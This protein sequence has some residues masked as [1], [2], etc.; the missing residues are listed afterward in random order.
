MFG[1]KHLFYRSFAAVLCIWLLALVSPAEARRLALVVGN[2]EYQNVPALK[3]ATNDARAM[4]DSLKRLGFEVTLLTD[5]GSDE[6]WLKLDAFSKEAETAESTMLFYSGHAFQLSGV[7]YLVPVGAKLTNRES[8]KTETW[9][10]DGIIARLQN[11]KR[12]T[13][14]FLDACR[15]DPL[16]AGVRGSGATADGLARLQTGV[17]T[18]VAFATEPGAVTFDGAGEAEHSPFTTAL[19]DNIEK[20]GLSVS[21]MMIKVRNQVEENT[22]RRQTPWDQS[23]LR[24][25]FYF[26]P[27]EETKQELSAADFE[28]LA[29]LAP[30]DRRKFLDLLRASGFNERSLKEAEAAI[31]V[32]SLDLEMAAE[33]E[34][35]LGD[36]GAD[37]AGAP[38]AADPGAAD[39]V[40]P[41]AFLDDL[42]VVDGGVTI[43]D[44]PATPD[45]TAGAGPTE[46]AAIDPGPAP[47]PPVNQPAQDGDRVAGLPVDPAAADTPAGGEAPPVRL[48]ALSWETRGIL[49]INALTVDRLRVA[50]K[51]VT[52]DNEENRKLL[53]SIDPSLVEEEKPE[54]LPADLAMA[55]QTE[56]KR[57]GCYQMRVD[58]DWGRGSRTALTSYFL[59]K[60]AVPDSL[61]PTAAL[62]EQLMREDKVVCT[63]RVATAK[64]RAGTK[65]E[66]TVAVKEKKKQAKAVETKKKITKSLIGVGSF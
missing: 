31:E 7:N 19:L 39:P 3:N 26:V 66:E 28:L 2:A 22:F 5:V 51:R 21:D 27:E 25:Q 1:R 8:I 65:P 11:R 15:N 32:A 58:G 48:A 37:Q 35:T 12:Q 45:T 40:D 36:S 18:F 64:P 62:V 43:G 52:P 17:G 4:A 29:Q 53:A 30:D 59:A 41:N 6:F 33:S 56:L 44:A 14:I 47:T 24:S 57:L 38:G 42:V 50:G 46:V 54:E 60:R 49:G 55:A 16:P 34:V 20:P 23:S 9:S 61:E 63:V 10:L 13:L